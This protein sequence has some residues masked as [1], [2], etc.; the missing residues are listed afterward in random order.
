LFVLVRKSETELFETSRAFSLNTGNIRI[1][2][3]L[4]QFTISLPLII[5]FYRI[6]TFYQK[7][8]IYYC[9]LSEVLYVK[10]SNLTLLKKDL[11]AQKYIEKMEQ[12][13]NLSQCQTQVQEAF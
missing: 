3:D 9:F 12:L 6:D 2:L 8:T 5:V 11:S 10:L 1:L 13:F 4:T 7:W